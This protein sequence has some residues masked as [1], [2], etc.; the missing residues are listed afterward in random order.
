MSVASARSFPHSRFQRHLLLP[1]IPSDLIDALPVVVRS[2]AHFSQKAVEPAGTAYHKLCLLKLGISVTKPSQKVKKKSEDL[3]ADEE[4][5]RKYYEKKLDVPDDPISA[6][7][8]QETEEPEQKDKDAKADSEDDIS[9]HNLY[10]VLE[11]GH[12]GFNASQQQ[13]KKAYQK[14]ILKHHPDKNKGQ[15]DPF[16]LLIQKA[17]DI[18]G[19]KEKRRGY[20]SMLDFD[21]WVPD[22]TELQPVAGEEE[23]DEDAF[24]E[25]YSPVFERNGRFSVK[26]PVPFLGEKTTPIE[27]VFDFYQFWNRF[28]SWR[29]F[30]K[31]DEF[32]D[33]D[34]E[35]ASGRYEKRWMQKQNENIR[36]KK[37]KKE[38]ER[39]AMLVQRAQKNDPRIRNHQREEQAEK[40]RKRKEREQ[41][42]LKKEREAAEA[43]QREKEAEAQRI[44]I[45]KAK[46]E[47]ERNERK[48]KKKLLKRKVKT[49]MKY[50]EAYCQQSSD[51]RVS[52]DFKFELYDQIDYVALH[53]S[54]SLD[55][56][57]QAFA[58]LSLTK[59]TKFSEEHVEP[60]CTG[61]D[62]IRS[63]YDRVQGEVEA[64]GSKKANSNNAP[65]V[66]TSK[67]IVPWTPEELSALAKGVK[68][69][70]GGT[71]KRWEKI[72]DYVN[73]NISHSLGHERT[74]E[75]CISKVKDL[76]A[77]QQKLQ[78]Q[79]VTASNAFGQF[80]KKQQERQQRKTGSEPVKAKVETPAPAP[81]TP[82]SWTEEEQ[83]R[84]QHALREYPNSMEKAERWKSIAGFV[85]TKSRREC[86]ERYK[87]LRIDLLK[88]SKKEGKPI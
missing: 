55:T 69:F 24:F 1:P 12:L 58:D 78:T 76:G 45:E 7:L 15:E 82:S 17:W 43:L 5:R 16:F 42:K 34:I 19:S 10:E 56:L 81:A 6:K 39:I 29:E 44:A 65:V 25:L 31:Y 57:L 79:K 32:K 59:E 80:K 26:K 68:K 70:P 4:L 63:C 67:Q 49:L 71:R 11:I 61:V 38:Y 73:V 87:A 33:G 14:M 54:P 41:Q 72:A 40:E 51:E 48:Q 37:K 47:R 85:K 86:V 66:K 27:T 30:S 60:L 3:K 28:E 23:V 74:E 22:G 83:Q 84:L 52:P 13:I 20:D 9:E 35:N 75:H 46:A 50:C 36:A 62:L 88:K 8:F 18:L 64:K 53:D 77:N 21:D 2:V